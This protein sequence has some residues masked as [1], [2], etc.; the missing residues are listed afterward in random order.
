MTI[1]TLPV[2]VFNASYEDLGPTT[3]DRAIAL[4]EVQG[5]A[6]IIMVDETKTIRTMGG[7]EFFLPKIIRLLTM[8][9]VSFHYAPETWSREGVIKRDGAVCAY[10][11]KNN[12]VT[13]DHVLAK[14]LGGRDEWMN[15][16]ACCLKCNGAK[17]HMTMEEWGK[18]V[19]WEMTE[20]R[21]IPMKMYFRGDNPRRKRK[22]DR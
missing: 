11:G 18:P 1:A 17:S 8:R 21:M 9:K 2:R 19:L 22:K 7:R 14:H 15:T 10:C 16:V 13:V 4:V 12:G 3:L 20:E 5:R 6:E